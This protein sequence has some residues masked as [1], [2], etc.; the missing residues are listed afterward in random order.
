MARLSKSELFDRVAGALESGGWNYLVLSTD[1]PFEM[2]VYRGVERFRTRVYIWRVTHGGGSA[3][4]ANEYRIQIT[5]GVTRFN[6]ANVDRTVVL[7]WWEDI[8]VFAGF[9]VSKHLE[10]LG[11]SPSLQIHEETL[12]QA[13]VGRVATYRKSNEE[14]AVAFVP[15]FL[16]D[17]VTDLPALHEIAESRRDLAVLDSVIA[18]PDQ[19]ESAIAVGASEKRKTILVQ[20]ARQLRDAGF[21]DRVLNAYARTCAMCGVQLRLIDAAHILPAAKANN[22]ATSNGLALCAM[23]HRAFDRALVTVRPDYRVA[24]NPLYLTKLAHLK[25][26]GGLKQFRSMLRPQILLPPDRKDRPNPAMVDEGNALRGWTK[27]EMIA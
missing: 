5:S 26:S 12:R 9:D 18:A 20:I 1:H 13:A 14:I 22:D 7:G 11:S 24:I 6:T 25:L 8:G 19:A 23:H 4:A 17:Y 21:K 2:V 27:Y 3:R 15:S 10:T 16:G